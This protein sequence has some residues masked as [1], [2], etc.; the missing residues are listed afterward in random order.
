MSGGII[1]PSDGDA[2]TVPIDLGSMSRIDPHTARCLYWQTSTEQSLQGV[3][4]LFEKE[5]WISSVLLD[6]GVCGQIA[7]RFGIP[8]GTALYAPPRMVPRA[9]TFAAGPVSADAVLLADFFVDPKLKTSAAVIDGFDPTAALRIALLSA[10]VRDVMARGVHAIE[11]FA[12]VTS[13]T[14]STSHDSSLKSS[15]D[16]ALDS[17]ADST[18]PDKRAEG[19]APQ[20]PPRQSVECGPEYCMTEQSFLLENGFTVVQDD[21][22]FPRLRL[23]I[24]AG[25]Q[26]QADVEHA[27]DQL[28]IEAAERLAKES[29]VRAVSSD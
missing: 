29:S 9:S 13:G 18:P 1:G 14:T 22:H 10:V 20:N 8:V 3:D 7:E 4:A 16:T 6:W 5:A 26:W 17:S 21:P 2:I 25:H 24:D 19:S 27:L 12:R 15:P 23:E 11:T 28:F